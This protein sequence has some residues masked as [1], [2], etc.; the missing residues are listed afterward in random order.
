MLELRILNG[1][2]VSDGVAEMKDVG[3]EGGA[4]VEVGS[5][6]TLGPAADE[7][8][9]TGLYVLPGAVDVHFHCRAPGHPER[10]DFASETRAAATGGVTTVFEM[11]ISEQACSTPEV[12]ERRRELAARQCYVNFALYAGAAVK[13]NA[14]ALAMEECGAIGFKLFTLSPSSDREREFEGLWAVDEDRIY[15]ALTAIS[16]TGLVCT[17][18]A[19]NEALL[20]AFGRRS[21]LNGV[22]LRPPIVE[23]TA[24]ALVGALAASAKARIHVAHVTSRAA[25]DALRGVRAMGA[26]ATGETCPQYLVFDENAIDEFGAFAKVAPPLRPPEDASALWDALRDGTIEVV[27]S[28][29]A[30]FRPEEKTEASYAMAPQGMPTVET[31]VPILLDAALRGLLPIEV[32]VDLIT[33]APARRFGLFPRKGTI[34]PGSDADISL[35]SPEGERELNVRSLVSRAA[36]CGVMYEGMVLRGRPTR[37]IVGGRTVF[38][39]GFVFDPPAGRFVRPGRARAEELPEEGHRGYERSTKVGADH[40][41]DAGRYGRR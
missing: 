7:V 19:E 25:L 13:N 11:P 38:L 30:P 3:I 34:R 4:I 27:A 20:R 41:P 28:D 17:V 39:E 36:G 40:K 29:H 5:P 10:G 8:D 1:I 2:V 37:T 9:A 26:S 12:F 21:M 31:M 32:A 24:I 33:S 23:A 6:G 15:D 16:H 22:P 18:H 35:F 14:H